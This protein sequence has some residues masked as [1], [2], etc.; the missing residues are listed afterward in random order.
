M[1]GNTASLNNPSSLTTKDVVLV[2]VN[3]RLGAF[4]YLAHPELTTESND[5]ANPYLLNGPYA[6]SGNYGQMDLIA[7][8]Q[9]IQDNITVFGGDPNNVTLFGQA[10]GGSKAISLM[11][12]YLAEG[13][14]HKVICQSGMVPARTSISNPVD[15]T[16][17]QQRGEDLSIRLGGLSIAEM[18]R[19][20]F[21]EIV[22]ADLFEF[23]GQACLTVS[24]TSGSSGEARFRRR[25]S[26]R[27]A[28][29]F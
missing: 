11:A 6:G 19:L 22:E 25:S 29:S 13:L 7:A 24:S 27:R 8:L 14:F 17:A 2:T 15:L 21:S 23:R 5:P 10:G 1:T 18:R 3:H 12:S 16:T 4:G 20:P 9:W 28:R 26:T